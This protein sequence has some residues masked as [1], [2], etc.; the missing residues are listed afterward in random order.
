M[1]TPTNSPILPDACPL[2]RGAQSACVR[3]IPTSD[4]AAR[5]LAAL[6]IDVAHDLRGVP[7]VSQG[8]CPACGLQS[9]YPAR[10]GSPAFYAQLQ[11]RL[12]YYPG[13]KW[14]YQR[15]LS[16]V[17]A[18]S[19]QRPRILEIGCGDGSLLERF[20]DAGAQ[21]EG[22]ELSPEAVAAA[23]ARGL[24]VKLA[25]TADLLPARAGAFDAVVAFQ[26]LEHVPDPR[27]FLE[28]CAALLS[29]APGSRLILGVPN[30]DGWFKHIDDPLDLPPHHMT[31]W[32]R[33]AMR[34]AA[35]H[36][37]LRVERLEIE[38]LADAYAGHWAAGVVGRLTGKL[39]DIYT[40][41]GLAARVL[42]KGVRTLR[43]GR[44]LE[45]HT[46]YACMVR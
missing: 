19:S 18:I 6:G 13:D 40:P 5:W 11:A 24:D 15:A 43:L 37:G 29:P 7:Q 30:A 28:Q 34:H 3:S 12:P 1:P 35:A 46:L 36:L 45:G 38:P 4:L 27:G 2:C 42:S 32:G 25:T 26:V 21:S 41:P 20:R 17:R 33:Q 16:D 44:V 31:R 14:E 9:F 22:I 23:V 39:I 8:D 10:P